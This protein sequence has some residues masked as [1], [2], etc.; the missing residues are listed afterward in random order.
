MARDFYESSSQFLAS[1]DAEIAR[2]HNLRQQVAAAVDADQANPRPAKVA[3][4][5]MSE[6]ARRKIADA[7]RA[8]W[9]KQKK[10]TKVASETPARKSVAKKVAIKKVAIKQPRN[11]AASVRTSQQA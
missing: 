3:R 5:G 1:I 2:L 6:A 7:Q 8:R 11:K 4:R 9:A 10:A